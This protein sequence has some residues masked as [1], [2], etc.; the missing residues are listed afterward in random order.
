[1]KRPSK[2]AIKTTQH[3]IAEARAL[4]DKALRLREKA[5]RTVVDVHELLA[6]VPNTAHITVPRLAY[7]RRLTSPLTPPS[8]DG[9]GGASPPGTPKS[10]PSSRVSPAIGG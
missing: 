8:T 1:M 9:D 4:H 3:L 6:V 10:R 5:H 7:L 2:L